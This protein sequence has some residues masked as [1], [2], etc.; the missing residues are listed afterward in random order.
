MF[1]LGDFY[2]VNS[3]WRQLI[4]LWFYSWNDLEDNL[5]KTIDWCDGKKFDVSIIYDFII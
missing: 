1:I 5:T 3:W 4:F 2:S